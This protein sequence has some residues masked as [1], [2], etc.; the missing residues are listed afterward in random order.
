MYCD[1]G[2]ERLTAKSGLDYAAKEGAHVT[3]AADMTKS[4]FFDRDSDL[5]ITN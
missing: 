4:H 5:T 2:G 1:I 3:F